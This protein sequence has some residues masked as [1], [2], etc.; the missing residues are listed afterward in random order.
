MSDKKILNLI[1]DKLWS[2]EK[3]QNNLIEVVWGLEKRVWNLEKGQKDI[4][5][6]IWKLENSFYKFQEETEQNFEYTN[7]SINQA[8][9]KISENMEEKEK[10]DTIFDFLKKQRKKTKLS[11]FDRNIKK[12]KIIA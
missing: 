5:D 12:E 9:E 8:F 4:I 3:G 10:V 2:L 6:S 11:S 1:L 7:K